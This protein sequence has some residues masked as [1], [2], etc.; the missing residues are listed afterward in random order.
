MSTQ[1]SK[2]QVLLINDQPDTLPLLV[3]ALEAEGYQVIVALTF[4]DALAWLEVGT[5]HCLIVHRHTLTQTDIA[6]LGSSQWWAKQTPLVVVTS[7]PIPAALCPA[8]E[9]RTLSVVPLF[10]SPEALCHMVTT[11]MPQEETL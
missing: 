2:K 3:G 8:V 1:V 10:A 5:P 11:L 9:R 7:V 4:C 6:L